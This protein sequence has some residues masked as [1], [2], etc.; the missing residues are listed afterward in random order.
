MTADGFASAVNA[1]TAQILEREKRREFA[2][3]II[4]RLGSSQ[5]GEFVQV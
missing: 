5:C 1:F 2:E 3:D 4:L